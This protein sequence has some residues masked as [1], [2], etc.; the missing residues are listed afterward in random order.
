M[1]IKSTVQ[2]TDELIKTQGRLNIIMRAMSSNGILGDA[3]RTMDTWDNTVKRTWASLKTLGIAIGNMLLP[4]L[5]S[6]LNAVMSVTKGIN[7]LLGLDKDEID[8]NKEKQKEYEN[9]TTTLLASKKGTNSCKFA[10]EDLISKYPDFWNNI[11]HAKMS[12]EE[13]EEAVADS[14]KQFEIQDGILSQKKALEETIRNYSKVKNEL[15][16]VN[17]ALA[18]LENELPSKPKG[19][20]GS[21]FFRKGRTKK[22]I[23]VDVTSKI[24]QQ[25]EITNRLNI[26]E[27]S[28]D[29]AQIKFNHKLNTLTLIGTTYQRPF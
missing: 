24:A 27:Q 15:K 18:D 3:Q 23:D 7:I 5:K 20:A 2:N 29:V 22:Q 21:T 6:F 9:L 14:S 25:L 8:L 1:G 19:G 26:A 28:R 16:E 12:V 11:D 17:A 13:L 4:V 10:L